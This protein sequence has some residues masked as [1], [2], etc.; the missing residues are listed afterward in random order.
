MEKALTE[1]YNK[2]NTV[3]TVKC[4]GSSKMCEDCVQS[5]MKSADNQELLGCNVGP[6]VKNV[7]A[8]VQVEVKCGAE[9]DGQE[10]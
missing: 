3:P 7:Y 2:K 6:S 9:I 10:E 5:I 1:A 4:C 8:D